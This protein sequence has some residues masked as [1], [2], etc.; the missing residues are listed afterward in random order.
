MAR[1]V[2]NCQMSH[3]IIKGPP[4]PN[5]PAVLKVEELPSMINLRTL[6]WLDTIHRLS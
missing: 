4:G 3:G 1:I 6:R 5:A 2:N